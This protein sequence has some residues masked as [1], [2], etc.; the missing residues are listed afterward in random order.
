MLSVPESLWHPW[1]QIC[2]DAD[3]LG[4]VWLGH[5]CRLDMPEEGLGMQ[6]LGFDPGTP[7]QGDPTCSGCGVWGCPARSLH[8][9]RLQKRIKPL[10]FCWFA[11]PLWMQ[12]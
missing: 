5:L 10:S 3:V 2:G 4:E 7:K 12:S 1:A 9:G 8:S 6:L 11:G